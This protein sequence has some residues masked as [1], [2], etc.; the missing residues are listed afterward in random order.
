MKKPVEEIALIADALDGVRCLLD[1]SRHRALADE[2]D[3]RAARRGA[4]AL[5]CVLTSHLRRLVAEWPA[6]RRLAARRVTKKVR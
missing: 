2:D 1:T 6:R 4:P 3:E 5:L